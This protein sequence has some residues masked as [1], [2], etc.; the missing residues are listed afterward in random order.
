M[1]RR[2]VTTSTCTTPAYDHCPI[3]P[4]LGPAPSRRHWLVEH[5]AGRLR[6]FSVVGGKLT[7]CRQLAEETAAK[8]LSALG[9]KR[10]GDSRQRIIPGG[11]DYPPDDRSLAACQQELA[12][13]LGWS[14][15]QI[16]AA[17][18]LLGTRL[19]RIGRSSPLPSCDSL[20]GTDLPVSLARWMI[21]HEWVANL[22]DLVERRLMLLYEPGLSRR[23]LQQLAQLLVET[24]K[25][26][27][28]DADRDVQA[29]IGRLRAHFGM[30]LDE[31]DS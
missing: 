4:A 20:A 15:H 18:S 5:P 19:A 16:A 2:V 27:A 29:T 28:A 7:T 17:W 11:E 31:S 22:D 23:C 1:S 3:R 24:G 13:R 6:L 12:R 14:L 8:V 25:L 21:Q 30:R 26:S 10:L 9:R